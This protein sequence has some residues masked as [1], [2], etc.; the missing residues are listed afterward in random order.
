[1]LNRKGLHPTQVVAV[2]FT[3]TILLG[4]ALLMLPASAAPGKTT[5]FIDAFFTATSAVTV[6]GLGT[7]DTQTQWSFLG[8]FI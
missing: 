5:R 1:M 3:A 6:T 8:H 2:A 7:L 4:T